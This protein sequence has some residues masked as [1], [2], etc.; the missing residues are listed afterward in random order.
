[1]GNV[2]IM[3]VHS[4]DGLFTELL[5]GRIGE[6]IIKESLVVADGGV[7]DID[8]KVQCI[9]IILTVLCCIVLT[10]YCTVLYGY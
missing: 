5:D 9:V 6:F 7:G 2:V 4:N 1:M 10:L 8:Y 3:T